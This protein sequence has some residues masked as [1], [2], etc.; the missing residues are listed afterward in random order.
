MSEPANGVLLRRYVFKLYPNRAQAERL[1]EL[2]R[3]HCQL[4]N[5]CLQQRIEAYQRCGVTLTYFDQSTRN[6]RHDGRALDD[7]LPEVKRLEEWREVSADSMG[8]TAQ[9]VDRA[10]KAFFARAKKGAG[11][12]SF[13][14][15]KMPSGK[16]VP[17]LQS[18][19]FA[20]M[21]QGE[22][23][24]FFDKAMRAIC[25]KVLPGYSPEALIAETRLAKGLPPDASSKRSAEAA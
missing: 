12:A 9:R 13:D 11:A 17:V 1:E 3:L 10:F 15:L 4:Y 7:G 18:T 23:S 6:K 14:L 5:A 2:R 20:A 16:V 22:F 24:E 19:S 21:K 8:V 25:T